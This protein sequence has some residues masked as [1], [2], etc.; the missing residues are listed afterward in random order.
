MTRN[1]VLL[2]ATVVLL[3]AAC[4]EQD[5]SV[6]PAVPRQDTCNAAPYLGLIGQDAT[7]L[8]RILIMRPVRVI[9]PGDLVTK[10]FRQER[11][12]FRINAAGM[13]SDIDCG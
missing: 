1:C 5:R 9:R 12:N 10:D 2:A 11:I 13:I 6:P 4:A 8:E 3:M 7:A